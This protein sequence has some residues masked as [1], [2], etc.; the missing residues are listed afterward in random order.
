MTCRSSSYNCHITSAHQK[1]TNYSCNR[2]TFPKPARRTASLRSATSTLSTRSPSTRLERP[3]Y[4]PR[5]SA[6]TT[7]SRAVTVVRPSLSSTRRPRPPRRLSCVS[8]APRAR[9]RSSSLSSA[10]STSSWVVTRRP[11][12]P[13]SSSDFAISL[14]GSG[15][16][17]CTHCYSGGKHMIL[18][19]ENEIGF[20][21]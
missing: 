16:L 19:M 18:A 13:P 2:S 3:P 21:I 15:F 9:P 20:H 7:V 4:S 8:S 10:A 17:H 14:F 1:L 5:V 12:V 6:V 11:R